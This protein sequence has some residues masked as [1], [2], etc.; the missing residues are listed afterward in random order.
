MSKLDQI[1]ALRESR[2]S[3]SAP[4]PADKITEGLAEALAIARGETE[5]HRVTE[6]CPACGQKLPPPGFDKR[7]YQREYMRKRR[8]AQKT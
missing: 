5:P 7:A 8:A 6:H 2:F 1:R 4:R 3:G